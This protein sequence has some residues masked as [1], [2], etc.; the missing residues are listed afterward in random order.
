MKGFMSKRSSNKDPS[1]NRQ[2]C[3]SNEGIL[4]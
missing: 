4:D 2:C 1:C 3:G